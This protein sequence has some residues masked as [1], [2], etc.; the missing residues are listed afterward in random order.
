[1]TTVEHAP[2]LLAWGD[3]GFA[4]AEAAAGIARE[5]LGILLAAPDTESLYV[6]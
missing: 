5:D 1:M 6:D 3:N 2:E 4:Q